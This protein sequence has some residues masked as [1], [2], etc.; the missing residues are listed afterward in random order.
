M[1]RRNTVEVIFNLKKHAGSF[2]EAVVWATAVFDVE[3]VICL[4]SVMTVASGFIVFI[5]PMLCR[6]CKGRTDLAHYK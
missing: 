3:I 1:F 4:V 6:T 2:Y 5:H